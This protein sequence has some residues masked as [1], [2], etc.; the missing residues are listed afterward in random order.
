M[1]T[2]FDSHLIDDS[3][4]NYSDKF[5]L[6]VS[7]FNPTLRKEGQICGLLF[8]VFL[9][10]VGLNKAEKGTCMI[11]K[12]NFRAP[13]TLLGIGPWTPYESFHCSF[14]FNQKLRVT[15]SLSGL[16]KVVAVIA[17]LDRSMMR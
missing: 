3:H 13:T 15:N 12:D 14:L 10:R 2:S 16:R 11:D 5:Y 8:K 7:V 6:D 17:G 4:L 9:D 1:L